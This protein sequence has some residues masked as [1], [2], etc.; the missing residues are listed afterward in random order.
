MFYYLRSYY[1]LPIACPAQKTEADYLDIVVIIN[2]CVFFQ[3]NRHS[4]S[5]EKRVICEQI[6]KALDKKRAS[7]LKDKT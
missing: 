3:D 2:S 6:K 1:Y 4:S 7:G 5:L